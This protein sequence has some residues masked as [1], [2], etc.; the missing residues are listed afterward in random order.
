MK[1]R[2]KRIKQIKGVFIKTREWKYMPV[3]DDK[4]PYNRYEHFF[5]VNS[6]NIFLFL[7][8]R[9]LDYSVIIISIYQ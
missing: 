5:R 8:T 9:I 6:F 1:S 3:R 7:Q 4:V 2:K